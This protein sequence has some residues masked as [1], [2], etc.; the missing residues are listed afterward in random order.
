MRKKLAGA[1]ELDK[2]LKGMACVE[3]NRVGIPCQLRVE[4]FQRVGEAGNV[5]HEVCEAL[6][7][8]QKFYPELGVL[9][10]HAWMNIYKEADLPGLPPSE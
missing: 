2:L 5:P 1:L 7:F 8:P 6:G 10:R 4:V 3:G 9:N